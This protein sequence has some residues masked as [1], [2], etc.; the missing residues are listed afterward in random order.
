MLYFL[1][2]R[3]IIF[4]C[5]FF[6][7]SP[8]PVSALSQFT[9]DYQIAY[10]VNATGLTHVKYQISQTNNLSRV[11]ATDFSLSVSHTDIEN[12]RVKDMATPINPDVVL[13]NNIT[14]INFSFK[15]KI[16]GKDKTHA[17]SIEYDTRDIAVKT[18]SVWEINIPKIT[19][20]ESIN[21]LTVKLETPSDFPKLVFVDPKPNKI[22]DNLFTFSSQSLVNKPISALFG[23]EQFFKLNAS[24]YLENELSSSNKKTIALPPNTSYQ[25]VLIK[26]INPRPENITIDQDGNWLATYVLKSKEKLT[27]NL[28]Q[29]IK[30]SFTPKKETSIPSLSRYLE[31]TKT[32]DYNSL[33]FQK[34]NVSNIKDPQQVFNFVTNSL[35][36]NYSLVRKDP[37]LRQA[38]SFSLEHPT[39]AICTNFTDLFIALA[40]KNNIPAREI[41]GFAVSENEK[42]KPL[43]LSKDVLHAWP[44]YFD[45]KK[46][47][48]IQVD[49]TWTNTTNGVDYFNKLDLNHIAFTIHGQDNTYPL[50]AGFYKNPEKITKDI[51]LKETD[52][53]QFPKGETQVKLK[54]QKGNL[55]VINI[56]NPSGIAIQSDLKVTTS[57][58]TLK[59][60]PLYLPPFSHSEIEIDLNTRP[61]VGKS[62]KVMVIEFSDTKYTLPVSIKPILSIQMLLATSIFIIVLVVLTIKKIK[63][64]N[65]TFPV[66]IK[67]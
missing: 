34:I 27:I 3:K 31:P 23:S 38:A 48:W 32:W 29:I 41:Q 55:L 53:I 43:S 12:L 30:L 9:T 25:E 44:E 54:E 37:L 33:E 2:M 62:A 57:T 50:P 4:L 7:L 5:L 64:N 20:K 35:I 16:V 51:E 46:N 17:F 14:S 21:N 65:S 67:T 49:P 10:K 19:T 58:S 42:L 59:K 40:R 8:Q 56:E 63:K 22:V 24:Y 13:T 47:T 1:S 61:I 45:K 6:F 60:V 18:G 11:Y 39:Q 52:P 15:N 66:S 26:N 28:E 36:Y